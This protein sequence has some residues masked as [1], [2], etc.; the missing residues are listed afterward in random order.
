[1]F[2]RKVFIASIEDERGPAPE[3]TSWQNFSFFQTEYEDGE[4]VFFYVLQNTLAHI[5][6]GVDVLAQTVLCPHDPI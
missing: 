3:K 5:Y 6:L 4:E 1:M 2:V